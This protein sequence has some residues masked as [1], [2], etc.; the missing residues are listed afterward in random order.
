MLHVYAKDMDI[1]DSELFNDDL[2]GTIFE[3]I[4]DLPVMSFI[5]ERLIKKQE[6]TTSYIEQSDNTEKYNFVLKRIKEF[7]DARPG[8]DIDLLLKIA[9]MEWN[10][11]CGRK[12]VKNVQ[13]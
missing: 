6:E 5:K 10:Y 8:A 13:I 3:N 11:S 2:T 7:I 9:L 1:D 12:V 4:E